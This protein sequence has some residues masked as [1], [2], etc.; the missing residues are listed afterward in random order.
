[1]ALDLEAMNPK[2]SLKPDDTFHTAQDPMRPQSLPDKATPQPQ[3]NKTLQNPTSPKPYTL[4]HTPYKALN[5]LNP[6]L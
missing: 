5:H 2:S 6:T 1:M 3:K 4:N